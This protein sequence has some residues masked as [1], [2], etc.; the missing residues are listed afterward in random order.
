MKCGEMDSCTT[1][2]ETWL[3]LSCLWGKERLNRRTWSESCRQKTAL[4][5]ARPRQRAVCIWLPWSMTPRLV[6]DVVGL[7]LLDFGHRLIDQP[8]CGFA[9]STLGG[10]GP[11]QFVFRLLQMTHGSAHMGFVPRHLCGLGTETYQQ[12]Q[13]A[14]KTK[15][16]R[17]HSSTS[18]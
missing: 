13:N 17:A 12:C 2:C 3:G 18:I 1:W 10:C 6:R 11:L 4:P 9:V 7:A 8:H 5:L 16:S 14:T 15:N